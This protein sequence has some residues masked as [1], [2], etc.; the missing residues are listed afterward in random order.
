MNDLL[1]KV[2]CER[3]GKEY[4][5]NFTNRASVHVGILSPEI[6]QDMNVIELCYDCQR[7]LLE[8]IEKGVNNGK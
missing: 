5:K 2:A 6:M 4:F 3:C 1:I 7:E 8:W